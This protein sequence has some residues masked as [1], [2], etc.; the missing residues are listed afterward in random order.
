MKK[1]K[2]FQRHHCI[3]IHFSLETKKP[4]ECPSCG[5]KSKTF[6]EEIKPMQCGPNNF[7]EESQFFSRE[8]KNKEPSK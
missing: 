8:F 4:Y 3:K 2:Y 7:L 5:E 6:K 1:Y